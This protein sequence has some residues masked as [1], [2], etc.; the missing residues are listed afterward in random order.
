[1]AFDVLASEAALGALAS[2][3][4]RKLAVAALERQH[5]DRRDLG[6]RHCGDG[7]CLPR[8]VP[9]RRAE[10]GPARRYAY[11]RRPITGRRSTRCPAR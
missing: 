9:Q 7:L 5:A 8:I 1:M 2:A 6:Q 4:G 11:Q 3:E 10:I